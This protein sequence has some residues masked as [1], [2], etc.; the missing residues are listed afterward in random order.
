MNEE[1]PKT[2]ASAIKIGAPVGLDSAAGPV[3]TSIALFDTAVTYAY[4]GNGPQSFGK[5]LPDSLFNLTIGVLVLGRK[6]REHSHDAHGDEAHP[7]PIVGFVAALYN[8]FTTER[9]A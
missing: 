1:H 6:A 4:V 7:R 3:Q 8:R 2:L 5:M 9:L